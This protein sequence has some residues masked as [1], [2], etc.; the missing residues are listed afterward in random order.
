MFR[1][2][3]PWWCTDLLRIRIIPMY[4]RRATSQRP[5]LALVL[6]WPSGPRGEEVGGTV[7]AGETTTSTSTL[8]TTTTGITSITSIGPAVGIGSMVAETA[9]GS[10]TRRT[11]AAHP[12]A[13]GARLTNSAAQRAGIPF[14]TG[15][16]THAR[17][18]AT[19]SSQANR[20]VAAL[21]LRTASSRDKRTA[22]ALLLPTGNSRAGRTAVAAARIVS[23]TGAFPAEAPRAAV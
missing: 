6:A 1:A 15:R 12:M 13:T 21:L 7:A 22:A 9:T 18:R 20:I 14:Q 4:I 16:R 10:T 5:P 8:I 23:V 19:G 3:T 2:I 17:T 11:G